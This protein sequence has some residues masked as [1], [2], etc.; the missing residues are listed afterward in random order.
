MD[1]SNIKVE[2]QAQTSV[3]P[4]ATEDTDDLFANDKVLGDG[5]SAQARNVQVQ[6]VVEVA[7]Q[8]V[9]DKAP[10]PDNFVEQTVDTLVQQLL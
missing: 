8:S 6:P 4:V 1:I 10:Q 9:A 3:I 2:D 7:H 5:E